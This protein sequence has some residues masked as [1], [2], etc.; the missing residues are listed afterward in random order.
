MS[1]AKEGPKGYEY[2]YKVTA[3][4]ALLPDFREADIRVEK[5]GKEDITIRTV[6]DE[7]ETILEV[8]V[9]RENTTLSLSLLA[10]WLCHFK[11]RKGDENLLQRLVNDNKTFSIFVT[12]S[13]C[14]D[15][16]L[17]FRNKFKNIV[18]A[19]KTFKKAT[20]KTL[21]DS[22][23]SLTFKA[24]SLEQERRDFSIKQSIELSSYSDWR[25]LMAKIIIWEEVYEEKVKD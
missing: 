5:V 23:K 13:R 9:K 2:Q 17:I 25:N 7:K 21:L 19:A 15:D 22:I 18:S 14:S 6:S 16:T 4:L 8:Q 24:T 11:E 10:K 1:V 20:F 12:R 3:F